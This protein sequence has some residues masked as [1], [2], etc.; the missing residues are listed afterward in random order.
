[1]LNHVVQI[2]NEAL[3][4]DHTAISELYRH[5]VACNERLVDHP[6][7]VCWTAEETGSSPMVSMLGL[8][9]GMFATEGPYR[10][11]ARIS[12]AGVL[13]RF[14]VVE[15]QGDRPVA[16]NEMKVIG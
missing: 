3:F 12:D 16:A 10:I 13:Q 4:C 6:S 7:I 9:N 5:R 8:I 2:L 14:I 1:M 15:M 11:A